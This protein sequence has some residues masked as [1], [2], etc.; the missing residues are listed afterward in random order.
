MVARLGWFEIMMKRKFGSRTA[1][2]LPSLLSLSQ[3]ILFFGN[4]RVCMFSTVICFETLIRDHRYHTIGVLIWAAFWMI[5]TWQRLYMIGFTK[6]VSFVLSMSMVVLLG[7]GCAFNPP[8][9]WAIALI[10]LMQVPLV[11]VASTRGNLTAC[12][13]GTR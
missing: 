10:L 1:Y 3:I 11:F 8:R 7:W 2:V 6:I 13:L 12:A 9:T 5:I 4:L